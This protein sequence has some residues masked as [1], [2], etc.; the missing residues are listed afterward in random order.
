MTESTIVSAVGA[1]ASSVNVAGKALAAAI[2]AAMSQAVMDCYAE[3]ISDPDIH[4][5]RMMAARARIKAAAA[6]I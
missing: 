4:R 2:Q 1:A 5:D 6:P 3:G